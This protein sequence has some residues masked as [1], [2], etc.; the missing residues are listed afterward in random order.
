[1]ARST[2]TAYTVKGMTCEHC[3]SSV[4]DEVGEIEG[5][6]R[7][8]VD[9][10]TGRLAVQGIGVSAEAVGAAVA[11]TGYELAEAA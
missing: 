9:L 8:E 10:A 3:R 4:A 7:V 5:V 1:M 2:T 6:E 11:K